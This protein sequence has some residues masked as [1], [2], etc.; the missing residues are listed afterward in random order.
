MAENLAVF[1]FELT[2][3]QMDQIAALDSGASA[4]F[5]HRDPGIV[6]QIGGRRS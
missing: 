4:F 1:D 3:E 2:A 6:S 5:D